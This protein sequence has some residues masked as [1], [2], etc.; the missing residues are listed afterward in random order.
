MRVKTAIKSMILVLVAVSGLFLMS[1]CETVK[2]G[3]CGG[4]C[5]TGPCAQ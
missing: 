3:G 4:A 2:P 5:A 1:G